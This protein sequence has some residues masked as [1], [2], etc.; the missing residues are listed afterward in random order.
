M[1]TPGQ[2]EREMF[3]FMCAVAVPETE[4]LVEAERFSS[5]LS[6]SA[7]VVMQRCRKVACQDKFSLCGHF[8]IRFYFHAFSVSSHNQAFCSADHPDNSFPL[9]VQIHWF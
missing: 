1:C 6:L 8:N 3:F 9:S 7:G 5:T 2:R 4:V